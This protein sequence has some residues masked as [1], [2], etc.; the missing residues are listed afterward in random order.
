[1]KQQRT[2]SRWIL[3]AI[4]TAL[5]LSACGSQPTPTST[6][7]ATAAETT[8]PIV[9]A[10]GEVLPAQWTTL[11]FAQA[12]NLNELLVKEGDAV[13]AGEVIARLEAP[14]L[15]AALAQKQAAVKVA[16]A[17]LAQLTAAPR[18][19]DVEAAQQAVKAAQ[20]RVAAA[21]AQ[22]DRL[23]SAVTD[24]DVIQAQA[25]V[26]AAQIQKDQLHEAMDKILRKGGFA[27]AAGEPVANQLK[28]TELELAAAQAVL[29]DLQDGPTIDQR[30]MAEA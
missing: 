9:S 14:D 27:L 22:R 17:N 7:T 2:F 20:A 13:K 25:Q 15:N 29:T 6:P 5:M 21:T 8:A 30:R 1:M 3:L 4:V 19:A 12:G 23:Y 16:E 10:S 11:S 28:Y 18:P 24:A 26:A